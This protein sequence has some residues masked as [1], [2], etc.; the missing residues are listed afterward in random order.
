MMPAL[1]PGG[2]MCL[3]IYSFIYFE[4]NICLVTMTLKEFHKVLGLQVGEP[5]KWENIY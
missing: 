5:T 3:L 4:K 2:G 1:E